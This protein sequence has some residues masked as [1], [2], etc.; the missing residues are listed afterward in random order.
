MTRAISKKKAFTIVELIIVIAVIGIL[1]AILIP[2]F[3]NMIAKANA[4]SAL[5]DARNTLTSFLSDNLEVIDGQIA[6]SIVIFV[7]K[8]KMHYVYGYQTHGEDMGKLMQSAGNPFKYEDLSE[9]ITQYN[10][11]DLALAQTGDTAQ[12][13]NFA[14][15]L[16][17]TG[18][19]SG[20]KS[21]DTINANFIN[22]TDRVE[23]LPATTQVFDGFLIGM[24]IDATANPPGNGTN[25]GGIPG[26]GGGNPGGGDPTE[27]PGTTD[28]SV[29]YDAGTATG[30][31]LTFPENTTTTGTLELPPPPTAT[32]F[33]FDGWFLDGALVNGT[34]TVTSDVTI[35]AHWVQLFNYELSF[36]EDASYTLNLKAGFTNPTMYVSGND[37]S[38]IIADSTAT[39]SGEEFTG[40][41][42]QNSNT[43][44]NIGSV[45]SPLS[46][47]ADFSLTPVWKQKYTLTFDA[48]AGGSGAPAPMEFYAGDTITLPADKPTKTGFAFAGWEYNSTT[49]FA[50]GS[51]VNAPDNNITLTAQWV[52]EWT[53]D[54]II[55]P[56]TGTPP[57]SQT[58]EDGDS[59]TLPQPTGFSRDGYTFE[60]WTL[61]AETY[62]AGYV[63]TVNSNVTFTASWEL[64]PVTTYTVTY[65]ANGGSGTMTDA[66]SPY[67][68][69]STVTVSA[70]A[71][72][73][74]TGNEFDGWNTAANG[75][76]TGYTAGGSFTINSD[77]TLYAQWKAIVLEV[78]FSAGSTPDATGIPAPI[79]IDGSNITV[80]YVIPKYIPAGATSSNTLSASFNH[81]VRSDNGQ[82]CYPGQTIAV[83]APLTLTA[84]WTTGCRT[85]R[86]QTELATIASNLSANFVLANDIT[87]SDNWTPVGSS[88]NMFTG[89]LNGNG[90]KLSN[91]T[92]DY[93][94]SSKQFVGLI[95]YSNGTIANLKISTSPS[96]EGSYGIYGHQYVGAFVGR[97]NSSG[98]IRNCHLIEGIVGAMDNA[99]SG[100]VGGIVGVS[101]GG[102]IAQCSMQDSYIEAFYRGGGIAGG[103]AGGTVT[104][105]YMHGSVNNSD[106]A[107]LTY[108]TFANWLIN[109]EVDNIGGIAGHAQDNATFTNCAVDISGHELISYN[110]VAGIVG[111][112]GSTAVT[113]TNCYFTS[114]GGR[115]ESYSFNTAT[116]GHSGITV[117]NCASNNLSSLPA[118]WD[119]IIWM[120]DGGKAK[121]RIIP[122]F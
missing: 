6:A 87:M 69:G 18:S 13:E 37:V 7:E 107:D 109:N 83:S 16:Y 51:I 91:L 120:L 119:A 19:P 10:C 64:I 57:A 58:V 11:T 66:N 82:V 26:G 50:N 52:S 38:G 113:I 76:G 14:F 116:Y 71:F 86:T 70:N 49:Y 105:C 100:Y 63:Y 1:A 92:I 21:M 31:T 85:I 112:K 47:N 84:D 41:K 27:D 12:T 80:P 79:T 102:L 121:L 114:V 25:P 95:A 44:Y 40:W 5:S 88:S 24:F 118:S 30:N 103:V 59:I 78:V 45:P 77:V 97:M 60:G 81:W 8:A 33:N 93:Y 65:D 98:V 104:E 89:K 55:D 4:K 22:L 74:P 32:G 96:G 67:E 42:E 36:V 28:F 106:G 54:F 117:T 35:V 99:N 115:M 61:S 73:P 72:T 94:G 111:N 101:Y 122:V 46:I 20:N 2:A 53:V 62:D 23:G 39:K 9:L 68:A 75:S 17:P 34:I 108:G 110:K 29:T 48:G 15:Y 56:G 43:I 90:Y 3:S